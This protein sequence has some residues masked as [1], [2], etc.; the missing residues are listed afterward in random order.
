MEGERVKLVKNE[1]RTFSVATQ[2][3]LNYITKQIHTIG[4]QARHYQV[5]QMGYYV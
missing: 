4:E 1:R 3:L 5:L 2:T